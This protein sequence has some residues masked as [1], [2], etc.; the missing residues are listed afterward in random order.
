MYESIVSPQAIMDQVKTLAD[1]HRNNFVEIDRS[2]KNAFS[3]P[4]LG[5][6]E[7]I[8]PVGDGDSYFAALCTEMAFHEF[9]RVK[10]YPLSSMR[11]L[12]YG[13]DYIHVKSPNDTLVVGIS[14]S[15][16]TMRVVQ[17]LERVKQVAA[18]AQ[19]AALVGNT[20]SRVAGM[21]EKVISAQLPELGRSP[22][23]RTYTGSL[24]GLLALAIRIGEIKGHYSIDAANSYRQEIIDMADA[25]E[26]TISASVGIAREAAKAV[27]N[28]SFIS[29]VGSGPN[30]GS[31]IFSSAKVIEACGVFSVAQDLEEWAHVERFAYPLDYPVFMVASP[32]KGHWRA[33]ELAKAVKALGH[34]LMVVVDK[35]DEEI[36]SLADFV[37]PVQ[38]NDREEF[39]PLLYYLAGT[40]L[41]Y[42]M[43]EELGRCIFMRDNEKVKKMGEVLRRQISG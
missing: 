14:A 16:E 37:F 9:A 1:I 42:F 41:S 17:S 10:D 4:E 36:K 15:G 32:G 24:M 11:F 26:A 2:I 5:S 29:Y 3:E 18:G 8:Y 35:N 30:F 27:K 31:A 12:E 38:A 13:A 23:I 22:G 40:V 25:V 39:S 7:E 21:A 34:L 19:M 33:L 20:D 28:A 6:I 43:A